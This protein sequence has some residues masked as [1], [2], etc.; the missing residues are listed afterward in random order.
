MD[1]ENFVEEP[2]AV[3]FESVKGSMVLFDGDILYLVPVIQHP[4]LA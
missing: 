1:A 3:G 4:H 2:L